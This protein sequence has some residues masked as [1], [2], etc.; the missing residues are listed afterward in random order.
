[1]S[2]P[3][4]S[5]SVPSIGAAEREAVLRALDSKAVGPYGPFSRLCEARLTHETGAAQVLLT[6]SG[7]HALELA[8]VLAALG[9]GDEVVMPSLTYSSTAAAVVALGAVPVFADIRADTRNLDET[10]IEAAITPR[11]RAVL[12]VHYAGVACDMSVIQ[13]IAT[14]HRLLIIEDSAQAVMARYKG[15]I[16]GTFGR[17]GVLSFGSQKNVSGGTGGALLVNDPA[18]VSRAEMLRD[19]GTDR[20]QF[21]RGE[22]R[23]FTWRDFGSAGAPSEIEAALLSAQLERLAELTN[24][25]L[26]IWRRYAEGFEAIEKAGA[27]CRP[28]VPVDCAHNAH[29]YYLV[30]PNAQIRDRFIRYM[31]DAG[32]DC[33][34][35][36]QPLHDSAGGRRWGRVSGS[37]AVT[38]ATAAGLVRLPIW[39]DMTGEPERVIEATRA[40]VR[41]M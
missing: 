22:V 26:D 21:V 11:T 37:L 25:R 15:Q 3:F 40:F 17:V 5:F 29:L 7:T 2:K 41:Q 34:T 27:L 38:D 14:R 35:H 8:A 4:I 18:D 19:C 33:R 13:R 23:N 31:A 6:H 10:L 39:P 1:M 16:L 32:I 30:W 9:P 24:R 36:F 28:H 12:P 20:A